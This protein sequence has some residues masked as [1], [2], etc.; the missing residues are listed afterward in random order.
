MCSHYEAPTAEHLTDAFGGPDQL[1]L[2]LDLWPGYQGA[3]V[4]TAQGNPDTEFELLPGIFGLLPAWAKDQ[5][6][7]RHTYNA[8]TETVAEK[9]SFRNAWRK[10]QHC[11]I[12]A[13]AIYEPDWRSGKAVPTRFTRADGGM[14]CIAGL[15]EEWTDPAGQRIHSYSMLTINAEEHLLFRDYHRP[16]DEKRMVVILPN[17]VIRD[18][19]KA[20]PANSMEF[21]RQYPADRLNATSE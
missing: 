1:A 4:R 9:P 6:L 3:F 20:S 7:A 8:R 15:W 16:E 19:L 17:G 13:A 14:M 21:M 10:A 5:K 11:I 18:W 12:P 2:Q